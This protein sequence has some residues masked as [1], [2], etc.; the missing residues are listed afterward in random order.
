MIFDQSGSLAGV[1]RHDYLPFGEELFAG[2]GGRTISQGYSAP[3][4][5]RQKFTQKERDIETGLDY[6]GAR[7]YAST[8]GRFTGAD[9]APITTMQLVNPQ[10][11]NRY[12]YVA[13]NPLKFI[14]PNGAEKILI[15]LQTFIPQPTVTAP[16]SGR[17]FEGDGRNVGEPGGFR[18]QQ[19][20]TIETD[21]SKGGAEISR[22][23]D[24]GITHELNSD[25]SIKGQ[26]QAPGETLEAAVT[27]GE[28][29]VNIQLKGNERDPLISGAPGITYDFNINVQSQG[30]QGN[31]TVT[32]SGSHDKFPAY[33]IMVTRIE[34][35]KPTTTV[36]YGYDPR[37]TG[38]SVG[39]LIPFPG[40]SQTINPAVRTVIPGQSPPPPP[41]PQR[42]HGKRGDD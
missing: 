40:N 36:A 24:T 30:T 27:R 7:Y 2:T 34:Q 19:I 33:E 3:D 37:K 23:R 32:V 38:S 12:A 4:N 11:L 42:K 31:A 14:D 15:V 22:S 6:F 5:V 10:D 18:T 26:G 39:S 9:P 17:T 1:S 29:G 16:V 13:N 28:S 25:G 20:I 21:P 8:Q 41:P 35:P